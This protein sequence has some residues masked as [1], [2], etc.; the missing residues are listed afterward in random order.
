MWFDAVDL[1]FN[2]EMVISKQTFTSNI[3]VCKGHT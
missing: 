1:L 3:F 2:H